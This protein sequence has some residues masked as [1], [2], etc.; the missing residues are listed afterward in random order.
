MQRNHGI[1]HIIP[2]H[3]PF[4]PR[5]ESSE[6]FPPSQRLDDIFDLLQAHLAAIQGNEQHRRL[7][8]RAL[9]RLS[10]LFRQ[11]SSQAVQHI[12]D[13]DDLGQQVRRI[14]MSILELR[15]VARAC[16]R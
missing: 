3:G 12:A 11:I 8:V 7:R 4:Q 1:A 14:L 10:C 5:P 13:R 9:A 2:F 15:D 6:A 16:L